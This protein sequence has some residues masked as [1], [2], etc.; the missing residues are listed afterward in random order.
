M[1]LNSHQLLDDSLHQ[2]GEGDGVS[3]TVVVHVLGE[4][5]D[6]LRVRLRLE[7]VAFR[8]LRRR[9]GVDKWWMNGAK[10]IAPLCDQGFI[11]CSPQ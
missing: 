6:D 11:F 8:V 10:Y 2:R 5:G 9:R 4:L 1:N 7:L 3:L